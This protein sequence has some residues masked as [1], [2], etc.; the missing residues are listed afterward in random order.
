MALHVGFRQIASDQ[1]VYILQ[2]QIFLCTFAVSQLNTDL[3]SVAV[4]L[5]VLFTPLPLHFPP[6]HVGW[7]SF[8]EQAGGPG[9]GSAQGRRRPQHPQLSDPQTREPQGPGRGELLG[10]KLTAEQ[11]DVNQK[12]ATRQ[13]DTENY[14]VRRQPDPP[15]PSPV[16]PTPLLFVAE[17]A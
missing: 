15:P 17:R 5:I 1:I 2:K 4:F 3:I 13:H 12:R 9:E 14:E 8:P 7:S 11:H 16:N 10:G 6:P